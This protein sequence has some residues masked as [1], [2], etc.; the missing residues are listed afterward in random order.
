MS[1]E[2]TELT[3]IRCPSC[4]SLVPAVATR[5]RMCGHQFGAQETTEAPKSKTKQEVEETHVERNVLYS[6]AQEESDFEDTTEDFTEE[7]EGDE[8][9]DFSVAPSQNGIES[10][11][12]RKKRRRRRKKRSPD[13]TFTPDRPAD[14]QKFE[15]ARPEPVRSEPVRQEAPRFEPVRPEPVRPEPVRQE[16][17]REV[18]RPEPVKAEPV[19]Q[20][21]VRQEYRQEAPKSKQ[22]EAANGVLVGWLVNYA[23]NTNGTSIELRSG[24][25]FVARQRLR[26][27]DLVIPDSAISTPHC[28]IK[29]SK[30]SLQIQDLMSEQGTFIKKEGSASFVSV[31]EAGV[32]GHGDRIRFG[33]FEVV[34]CLVP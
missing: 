17:V 16:P 11:G 32:I 18:F 26:D 24:K 7:D 28:L 10:T 33:A 2:D 29:A 8:E 20:E 9:E 27:D 1:G 21:P 13:Q 12:V 31:E 6:E 5:C 23:Q 19:K 15:A 3:F 4:R 25:Y 34:V 30:G 22:A 14:A